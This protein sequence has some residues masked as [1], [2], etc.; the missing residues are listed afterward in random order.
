MITIKFYFRCLFLLVSICALSSCVN[1][2]KLSDLRS[3]D[4]LYPVDTDRA[5]QLLEEMGRAHNIQAWSEIETYTV[6]FKDDFYGFLGKQAHP[7]KEQEMTF[8]LSYIPSTFDGQMEII[9][10]KAKG[11]IWGI[12]NGVTYERADNGEINIKKNKDMGFWLPTYQY[13]IE[14]P[15]RIQEVTAVDYL[16]SK[17]ID[18]IRAEGVI[19][20]WDTVSTQKNIDQYILWISK[21]TKRIVK[22][23]YTVRDVYRFVTGAASYTHYETYGEIILP[24]VMP[25]ESNLVKDG[26]LH[27]MQL[28]NFEINSVPTESLRPLK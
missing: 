4:Y 2:F 10:G 26:L 6:Q 3:D 1:V 11:K 5:R 7:F 24:T 16:G 14:L 13:F 27:Q 9:S 12:Q 23:E 18:G 25:V 20:S 28:S 19:A 22:V 15:C 21:E 17:T 8:L